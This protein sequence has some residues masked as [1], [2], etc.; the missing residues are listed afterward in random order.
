MLLRASSEAPPTSPE[1]AL[2]ALELPD[3]GPAEPHV[4]RKLRHSREFERLTKRR[5]RRK[6]AR[7]P[8]KPSSARRSPWSRAVAAV[9]APE[10]A[11]RRRAAGAPPKAPPRPRSTSSTSR[12][13]R[14]RPSTAA[15]G[16]RR[17]RA[18][19]GRL[20]P[21]LEGCGPPRTRR[22]RRRRGRVSC[23]PGGRR[24]TQGRERSVESAEEGGTR[25]RG[26]SSR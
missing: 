2:N 1:H 16:R 10:P 24:E 13:R 7:S 17:G 3:E 15:V 20:H 21:S 9:V 11:G 22:R 18:G 4:R 8:K 23:S 12:R 5:P 14:R 26:E 19:A 6:T 25:G